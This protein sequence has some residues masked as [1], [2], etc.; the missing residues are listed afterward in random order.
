MNYIYNLRGLNI[1]SNTNNNYFIQCTTK[2]ISQTKRYRCAK[3]LMHGSYKLKSNIENIMHKQKKK[4]TKNIGQVM[5][6]D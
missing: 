4:K 6:L 5:E 1:N 2:K 3:Y